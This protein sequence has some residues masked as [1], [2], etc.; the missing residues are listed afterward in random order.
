MI[1]DIMTLPSN[2][3]LGLNKSHKCVGGRSSALDAARDLIA[4]PQIP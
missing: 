4:L 1:H 2:T 3:I